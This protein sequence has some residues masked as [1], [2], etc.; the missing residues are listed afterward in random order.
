METGNLITPSYRIVVA[1]RH[2]LFRET[3]K[4]ALSEMGELV[5]VGEASDSSSLLDLLRR[6]N[7]DQQDP[8]L[9]ILDFSMPV[10]R[11]IETT[12]QI[13]EVFPEVKV[14]ILSMDRDKECL[15]CVLAAG[16]EGY[17]LKQNANTEIFSAVER[18][19]QGGIY[20][21]P[22]M[23]GKFEDILR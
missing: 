16:A 3:L 10:L 11:G 21:S 4:R 15:D 8:Q 5:V 19:K 22:G 2:I 14:L 6:L 7:L 20:I 9:V 18:I 1:D 13:K 23:A 17:V 12:R